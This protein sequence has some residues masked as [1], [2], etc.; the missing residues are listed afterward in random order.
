VQFVFGVEG[1]DTSSVEY[2]NL[3]YR[4]DIE[5]D[6]NFDISPPSRQQWLSDQCEVLRDHELTLRGLV[7]CF[8]DDYADWRTANGENFP[9]KWSTGNQKKQFEADLKAFLESDEGTE[10]RLDENVGFFPDGS[11]AIVQLVA[12]TALGNFEPSSIKQ[13]QYDLWEAVREDM[14]SDWDEDS[15]MHTVFQTAGVAWAWMASEGAFVDTAVNGL[16]IAGAFAFVALLLSTQNVVV[17]SVACFNIFGIVSSILGMIYMMGWEMGITESVSIVILV[18]FSVDYVVHLANSYQESHAEKRFERMSEAL[19]EMGISVTAGAVTTFGASLFLWGCTTV[20]FTKFAILMGLTTI[21]SIS[22][23]LIF[24]SAAMMLL[25]PEKGFGDIKNL[26]KLC[27][28]KK[29]AQ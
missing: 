18:G 6:P 21:F 4:G 28:P 3:D 27:P 9:A 5:W 11:L 7:S 14:Q 12:T 26:R 22:W 13:P 16:M 19:R 2:Y 10:H 15:G 23:S 1:L 20:F 29:D 24:F 17:S 25:G 8:I